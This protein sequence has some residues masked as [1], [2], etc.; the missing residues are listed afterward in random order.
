MYSQ[1]AQGA[2]SRS[3]G[4][5]RDVDSIGTQLP[6][7]RPAAI[8]PL[9]LVV[10]RHGGKSRTREAQGE[11]QDDILLGPDGPVACLVDP[12]AHMQKGT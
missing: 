9:G 3:A 2:N 1:L 7:L 12:G 6:T 10:Y 5:T 8:C 11:V 4:Y